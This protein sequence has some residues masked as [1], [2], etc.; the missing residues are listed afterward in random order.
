MPKSVDRPPFQ[1]ALEE[2][3]TGPGGNT[4]IPILPKG[5][6]RPREGAEDWVPKF[7]EN[8]LEGFSISDAAKNA[9]VH[10]TTI[11]KRRREDEA[12][13]QA[14]NEACDIGTR[15]LEQEAQ[16]RAFHGVDEPVFQKGVQV[17]TIRKYS[18]TLLIFLLKSRNPAKYR[19]GAE[20]SGRGNVVVNINVETVEK[21]EVLQ[22]R[23]APQLIEVELEDVPSVGNTLGTGSQQDCSGL[24]EAT[25]VP[26]E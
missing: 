6:G 8:L 21:S 26:P 9:N 5:P 18:D 17:G 13:R 10:P 22:L 2:G 1:R 14:W 20:D 7:L 4:S 23:G 24:P 16:R 12:F 19:E 3:L 25:A 15:L 11:Y